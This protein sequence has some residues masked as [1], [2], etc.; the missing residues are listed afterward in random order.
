MEYL[1]KLAEEAVKEAIKDLPAR[2]VRPSSR[3]V[4]LEARKIMLSKGRNRLTQPDAESRVTRA[5]A[6]MKERKDIKAPTA[7]YTDWALIDLGPE[8]PADAS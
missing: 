7:P 2:G 5:I 8:K 3:T 1:D 4:P 6:R